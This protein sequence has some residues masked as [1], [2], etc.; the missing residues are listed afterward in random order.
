MSD[1]SVLKNIFNFPVTCYVKENGFLGL[2]SYNPDTDD[3]FITT[4][5]NP[6]GDYAKWLRDMVY[7]K[8]SEDG[9]EKM[10]N[11]CKE[12]NVTFAFE[13]VDM[14][15]DPHIIKYS[16]SELIL[17]SIIRNDINFS[18]YEYDEIVNIANSLGIPVK[19][20]AFE[21]ST[22]AEFVDWYREVL[23]PD[24]EFDGKVIEGFVIEDS[25]GFMTKLKLTYYNFWK[26]MRNI[27]H[28]TLR[29]GYIQKTSALT[30]DVAND[31]YGYMKSVYADTSKEDIEN[32]PKDICYWRDR[33]YNEYNVFSE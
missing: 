20:K 8:I 3:L 4:K 2:V 14:E 22:W 6:D 32:F 10:K 16:D 13:C 24:Y 19:T 31:F 18:Q 15:H 11:I 17:L 9:I 21:I 7:S 30:N 23:E 1:I 25:S 29:R 33:F 26:F 12:Q 27:C 5:S 28:E